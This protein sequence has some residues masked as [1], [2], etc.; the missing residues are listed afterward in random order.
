MFRDHFYHAI[1]R[2]SVAVFGTLFNELAVVRRNNDGIVKDYTKVPLSYGPKQKFLARLDQQLNLDDPKVALKLPRMSFEITNLSYDATTKVSALNRITTTSSENERSSV[3]QI[4]PYTVD[5]Q[6]NIIAKNQDDALQLLEQ[7]VPYFQPTYTLSVKFIDDL[8]ESFDVPINL[9][10]ITLQDDYEGDMTTRR[11]IIYTL[12]FSMKIKFFGPKSTI[13]TINTVAIDINDST[14]YGFIEEVVTESSL[15]LV[16]AEAQIVLNETGLFF[17]DI[18]NRGRGYNNPPVVTISA[19]TSPAITAEAQADVVDG[20]IIEINITNSGTY[21]KSAPT[22]EVIGTDTSG[23]FTYNTTATINNGVVESIP[24][25]DPEVYNGILAVT[26][27]NI[28][29]PT[30]TTE[31]FIATAEA[32]I[33][34]EGRIDTIEIT[35]VGNGYDD[36]PELT[37][38]A[39][40]SDNPAYSIFTGID[41]VDDDLIS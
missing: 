8:D 37:I 20:L 3:G 35:S 38:A 23:T 24:L 19:P 17:V 18:T 41:N 28:D 32:T 36:I 2:K 14:S 21:Y 25:P 15:L 9:N 34:D 40:D 30:G 33:T 13:G 7:I 31:E 6:L 39:P 4:T 11:S 12:D 29:A 26:T 10:S 27:I 22:V 5:M 1:L 16:Q